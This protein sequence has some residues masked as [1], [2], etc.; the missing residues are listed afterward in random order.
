MDYTTSLRYAFRIWNHCLHY[1]SLI[2][3]SP[4]RWAFSWL[5]VWYILQYTY[6]NSIR[7]LQRKRLQATILDR[8]P[9]IWPLEQDSLCWHCGQWH[10]DQRSQWSADIHP[11]WPAYPVQRQNPQHHHSQ[12][13]RYQEIGW[14]LTWLV[15]RF[16]VY[17]DYQQPLGENHCKNHQPSSSSNDRKPLR[18]GADRS[19]ACPRISPRRH[20]QSYQSY[21]PCCDCFAWNWAR[22]CGP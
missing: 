20:A 21:Q 5:F 19:P 6:G 10:S 9:C 12:A 11:S 14:V 2:Q 16:A 3:T 4:L 7:L 22:A 17:W 1:D 18:Y 8:W 13:P 15:Q